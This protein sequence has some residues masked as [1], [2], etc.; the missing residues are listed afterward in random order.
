MVFQSITSPDNILELQNNIENVFVSNVLARRRLAIAE[1]LRKAQTT[2]EVASLIDTRIAISNGLN[3]VWQQGLAAGI[4]HAEKE[5]ARQTKTNVNQ[6]SLSYGL[7]EAANTIE[8]A[9]KKKRSTKKLESEIAEIDGQIERSSAILRNNNDSNDILVAA[10]LNKSVNA[11][12]DVE[13]EDFRQELT[14]EIQQALSKRE[15]LVG[16]VERIQAEISKPVEKRKPPVNSEEL[17]IQKERRREAARLRSAWK[18]RDR[19]V[20]KL[21]DLQAEPEVK[22]NLEEE[23]VNRLGI[24]TQRE[25][26]NTLNNRYSALS[27]GSEFSQTYLRKRQEVLVQSESNIIQDDVKKRIS[28]FVSEYKTLPNQKRLLN[29]LGDMYRGNNTRDYDRQIKSLNDKSE[30]IKRSNLLGQ[31][32]LFKIQ[33]ELTDTEDELQEA[34]D[35]FKKRRDRGQTLSDDDRDYLREL[36]AQRKDLRIRERNIRNKRNRK[37]DFLEDTIRRGSITSDNLQSDINDLE[38]ILGSKSDKRIVEAIFP[39]QEVNAS[40]LKEAQK[41]LRAQLRSKKNSAKAL[42]SRLRKQRRELS[43]GDFTVSQTK[44]NTT[45]LDAREQARISKLLGLIQPDEI[46]D[47]ERRIANASPKEARKLQA[48][49]DRRVAEVEKLKG[50]KTSAALGKLRDRL[51]RKRNVFNDESAAQ[52]AT[53][54]AAT[55][56]SAAYNLGR[57]QVFATKGIRYVQWIATIDSKTSVFCQSLHLKVFLLE[58]VM[59]QIMFAK[60][61]PNTKEDVDS[62]TN[63]AV[64]PGGIWVPPAHPYCRSYLQPVYLK[65]DE[66][67]IKQDIKDEALLQN[68]VLGSDIEKGSKKEIRRLK[69]AHAEK[70]KKISNRVKF[71]AKLFDTGLGFLLRRLHQ[72]KIARLKI[73]EVKQN[74]RELMAA[75]LGGAASLSA[76]SMMYFF[77]K[78]NLSDVLAQYVQHLAS[79]AF[80]GGKEF[81]AGMTKAQAA[82]ILKDISDEINIM[83]KTVL[84]E[85][86]QPLDLEKLKVPELEL[87]RLAKRGEAGFG[88]AME[89]I[90]VD[91]AVESLLTNRQLSINSGKAFKN[92]VYKEVLN[93]TSSEISSLRK[94]GMST[95]NEGLGDLGFVAD[96][97]EDIQELRLVDFRLSGDPKVVNVIFKKGKGR[98][99]LI[100]ANRF[101]A[102]LDSRDFKSKMNTIGNRSKDLE[103]V[104]ED[105]NRTTDKND[106]LLR[107]RISKELNAV[108]RLSTLSNTMQSAKGSIGISQT[109]ETFGDLF[110]ENS[111]N[112]NKLKDFNTDIEKLSD[113]ADTVIK[114]FA[115]NLP[116]GEILNVVAENITDL[117][118]LKSLSEVLEGAINN[119]ERGFLQSVEG[120]FR[121]RKV[122][123]LK[124][125]KD[126]LARLRQNQNDLSNTSVNIE[127]EPTLDR[128]N[129]VIED[130]ILSDYTVLQRQKL[131]VAKRIKELE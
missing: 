117:A 4:A 126:P 67:K 43:N 9:K 3:F 98:P 81:L 2:D 91:D 61:F 19:T 25:I 75:L 55:E 49:L 107:S 96:R 47:L 125:L 14:N 110:E 73:E 30:E 131:E 50:P 21:A 95:L 56:V 79:D 27:T 77:L 97:I 48:L 60:R 114:E 88:L 54:L 31:E 92:K 32:D 113:A 46:K 42:D 120:K 28:E 100:S 72:D 69:K 115:E 130:Q 127:F 118:E 38:N 94:F 65:E 57:L 76:S 123:S 37:E 29:D 1:A 128:I 12:T 108:K 40:N 22:R 5:I 20:R 8:F 13:R 71:A 41:A 51:R 74:D 16:E 111:K 64:N 112:I 104:L 59:S 10:R 101:S 34:L 24:T 85:F 45:E 116:P 62:T 33:N 90:P 86:R 106:I 121:V 82:K 23:L 122:Q 53:R 84:D 44:G 93:K 58:D 129:K 103:R 39:G 36:R 35:E 78:S 89:G 80:E 17:K 99:T 70:G 6:F 105:L 26:Q 63:N 119:I 11:V 87:E 83:P 109:R 15:R 52:S 102:A 7:V 66:I 124:N 68:I 18:R